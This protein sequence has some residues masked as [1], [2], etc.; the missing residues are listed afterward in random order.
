MCVRRYLIVFVLLTILLQSLFNLSHCGE[1][2]DP[3][4][5]LCGEEEETDSWWESPDRRSPAEMIEQEIS[6]CTLLINM[7]RHLEAIGLL[8][9]LIQVHPGFFQPYVARGSAYALEKYF[10]E[11]LAD[12]TRAIELNPTYVDS[13]IRR[14]Q[15]RAAMG[16]TEG[17]I[18]DLKQ[19]RI[20]SEVEKSTG[21]TE[22]ML[23]L[24]YGQYEYSKKN[25][26]GAVSIFKNALANSKEDSTLNKMVRYHLA[27]TYLELGEIY[28]AK[29]LL[30]IVLKLDPNFLPALSEMGQ[31]MKEFNRFKEADRYFISVIDLASERPEDTLINQKQVLLMTHLRIARFRH[32]AGEL[33][34]T[35]ESTKAAID[36]HT[37]PALIEMSYYL[38]GAYHGL[39]EFHQALSG[40][41]RG[42]SESPTHFIYY[43]NEVCKQHQI[44]FDTPLTDYYWDALFS[45]QFK[46][47][48]GMR[49]DTDECLPKSY[50]P[51]PL[52]TVASLNLKNTL[53]P[54]QTELLTLAKRLGTKI[55]Y[56]TPGFVTNRKQIISSGLAMLQSA[57]V[58]HRIIKGESIRVTGKSSSHNRVPHSFGWRDFFDILVRW[59]Q[60]VEPLDPVWWIDGLTPES[61]KKGYGTTTP[62]IIGDKKN[63]RYFPYFNSVFNLLKYLVPLQVKLDDEQVYR[64]ITSK[65]LHEVHVAM[66]SDVSVLSPCFSSVS[67]GAVMDGSRISLYYS[68]EESGYMFE[69][70]TSA[71]PPRWKLFNLE[72][73]SAFQNI[74]YEGP[75]VVTRGDAL[76]L[77][78]TFAYYWFQ[79]MPLSRGSAAIGVQTINSILLAFGYE[80]RAAI[81]KGIQI[82]WEAMVSSRPEDFMHSLSSWLK[83]EYL[84]E[85]GYDLMTDIPNVEDSIA[86]LRDMFSMV[87]SG[88]VLN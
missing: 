11:A 21:N 1:V 27:K 65:T 33:A 58:M 85:L 48:Y 7:G 68:K 84:E 83:P 74:T 80:Y 5:E 51:L 72:L 2:C 57:Q 47:C 60:A 28:K 43:L 17:S 86:S 69:V 81:P 34:L 76:S 66:G 70:S 29:S 42:L 16:N 14:G 54:N 23:S 10:D 26:S 24:E 61:F 30:D 4:K 63:I 79:F 59:R 56:N 22:T 37:G 13:W 41:E 62:L 38:G 88:M 36:D 39:G 82:D 44:Y 20:I 50:V 35:V 31:V 40:Y 45:P 52:S 78:L 73:Q 18:A 77:S 71:V 25:F 64:I 32:W 55:L 75:G 9:S 8:T 53:T 3:D 6:K 12:M 87:N 46:E 67:P 15:I 49:R 19:A